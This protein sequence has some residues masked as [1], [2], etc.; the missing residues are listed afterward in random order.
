MAGRWSSG[1]RTRTKL[2]D[3]ATGTWV[4]GPLLDIARG[5]P[6]AATLA[7]GRVLIGS[8]TIMGETS[9]TTT[10]EILDADAKAW[11]AAAPIQGLSASTFT[12]LSDGRLMAVADGFELDSAILLF[13]PDAEGWKAIDGPAF[14]RQV[15][16]IP[17]DEGDALVFGYEELAIGLTATT[18]VERFDGATGDWSEVAPL[19]TPRAGSMLTRLADGRILVAGGATSDEMDPDARALASTEIFDPVTETWTAGP[20][21]FEPR[22][23]GH[24][25]LLEDGGVLIH[26]GDASFNVF[27][28]VP[29]C[30]DP[31]TSTERIYLGS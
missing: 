22:K 27:G 29:W 23:D 19:S 10:T 12:A 13:D 20:D 8:V 15:R 28:D 1:G 4:D 6:A 3:P 9:S 5:D 31:M 16:V 11:G 17:L 24:A 21:L 2:F 26:G 14:L 30:P 7:D 18:R 25:L